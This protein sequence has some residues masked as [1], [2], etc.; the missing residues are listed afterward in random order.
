MLWVQPK[1]TKY[2]I[3]I[4]IIIIMLVAHEESGNSLSVQAVT[5]SLVLDG[6]LL[7]KATPPN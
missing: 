5:L 6:W 7:A 4:I 1:K 2:I 3:I